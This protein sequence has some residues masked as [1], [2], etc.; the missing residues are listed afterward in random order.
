MKKASLVVST[1]YQQ[2]N[3]FDRSNKK[4]NRDDCLAPFFF[5]K[6]ELSKYGFDLST[7]DIHDPSSS[8]VVIYNDMPKKLPPRDQVKK[9][10]LLIL[11]SPLI[12]KNSWDKS[13]FN[14]FNSVFS[15][16]D[17]VC[18][19][20]KFVK[21]NYAFDIPNE[22]DTESKRDGFCCLI[23]AH[24]L[25]RDENE[26][27]SERIKAIRW[28]EENTSGEFDLY[29]IGWDKPAF[30]GVL[31]IIKK[32]PGLIKIIPFKGFKSYK[33][34]V[35]SKN[36]TLRNYNFSICYEN[37]YGLNGYITEKIFDC[38]FAGTIPIYLGAE[39]ILKYIPKNCFID[40]RDFVSYQDLYT[41]M[42]SLS[43]EEIVEYRNNIKTF[44]N[45]KEVESFSVREFSERVVSKVRE[46]I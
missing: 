11:E 2:N 22:L 25:S 10:F 39:N 42:K 43:E 24:K 41:Y 7:Q 8:D 36:E 15:W 14:S 21:V 3:I 6:K 28:F 31:K 37:I 20:E 4:L 30:T 46:S 27:Y 16:N 33:G 12:V 5:L 38:F 9:S 45:S 1:P 17:D 18:D 40:K 32:I 35:D 19:G 26:L 44:L 23:S 29:G 13:R 34:M